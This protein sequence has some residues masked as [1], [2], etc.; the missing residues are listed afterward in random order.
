MNGR[1]MVV[2][3]VVALVAGTAGVV[4]SQY[5]GGRTNV[6]ATAGADGAA[7]CDAKG[8]TGAVASGHSCSA[9]GP[10]GAATATLAAAG[11]PTGKFDPAM[12]GACEGSCAAKGYNAADVVA[13]P[14]AIA[15]KLTRC[16]VSGVVFTVDAEHPHVA[17]AGHEYV[18]CCDGCAK[19]FSKNPGRFVTS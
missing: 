9:D 2:L 1:L 3:A 19:K 11:V 16:P 17:Y 10:E 4:M 6:F 12:S 7:S 18:L 13:Q 8:A 15:G 14:G 5:Y